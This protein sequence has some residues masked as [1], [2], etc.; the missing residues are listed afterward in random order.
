MPSIPHADKVQIWTRLADEVGLHIV[1]IDKDGRPLVQ[2]WPDKPWRPEWTSAEDLA[3]V[4]RVGAIAAKA[5]YLVVDV[6]VKDAADALDANR[7]MT[8]RFNRI[9]DLLGTPAFWYRTKSGGVHL[10]YRVYWDAPP[11]K[12]RYELQGV[13]DLLVG[14]RAMTTLWD[15]QKVLDGMRERSTRRPLGGESVLR[16]LGGLLVDDQGSTNRGTP[17]GRNNLLY[18]RLFASFRNDG[19]PLLAV[20]KAVYEGLE[21]GLPEREVLD[22]LKSAERGAQERKERKR[23]AQEDE[24]AERLAVLTTEHCDAFN[25][26]R[27]GKPPARV[28]VRQ[29]VRGQPAGKPPKEMQTPLDC[30]EAMLADKDTGMKAVR[31]VWPEKAR[32]VRFDTAGFVRWE[33]NEGWSPIHEGMPIQIARFARGKLGSWQLDNTGNKR[34]VEATVKSQTPP[35][36]PNVQRALAGL[37]PIATRESDWDAIPT[38]AMW[39]DGTASWLTTGAPVAVPMSLLS[40]LRMGAMPA[41]D[42]TALDAA[43]E[44]IVPDV[45]DREALRMK[46]AEFVFGLPLSRRAL[47]LTGPTGS[48]KSTLLTTYLNAVGTLGVRGMAGFIIEDGKTG[49]TSDNTM[50]RVGSARVAVVGDVQGRNGRPAVFSPERFT[51]MTGGEGAEGRQIGK[52]TQ[53]FHCSLI[54]ACNAVPLLPRNEAE[55]DAIRARLQIVRCEQQFEDAKLRQWMESPE[56]ASQMARM[57]LDEAPAAWRMRGFPLA[58]PRSQIAAER[59]VSG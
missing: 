52:D 34:W 48:W 9:A 44:R 1:P 39:P 12:H 6:D 10:W 11:I 31:Y 13:G 22:T 58:T 46:L 24:D 51:N 30:A 41:K 59:L 3:L 4:V 2:G 18:S 42:S 25:R 5:G 27:P 33:P 45:L 50:S 35:F 54:M 38:A 17:S 47:V 28:K 55:A 49:F 26:W 53:T 20:A 56:A 21:S 15:P 36:M 57:I 40:R 7:L 14:E 23:K 8:E 19:R 16:R 32:G 37:H 29:S 43:L